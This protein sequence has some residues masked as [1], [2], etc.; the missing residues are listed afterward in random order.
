MMSGITVLMLMRGD[1]AFS[2]ATVDEMRM[3]NDRRMILIGCALPGSNPMLM[4]L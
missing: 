4:P 1:G 3:R 2:A